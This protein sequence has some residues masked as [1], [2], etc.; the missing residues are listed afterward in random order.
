MKVPPVEIIDTLLVESS[1]ISV[2]SSISSSPTVDYP[3][4]Q[5]CSSCKKKKRL[6]VSPDIGWVWT[7]QRR[8]GLRFGLPC[9][10]ESTGQTETYPY[11][12]PI[13]DIGN[14]VFWKQILLWEWEENTFPE[15]S[16][17]FVYY[18]TIKREINRRLPYECRCDERLKPKTKRSTP[19]TYTGWSG[20]LEPFKI[21][22]RLI[23][24]RFS[25]VMGECVIVTVKVLSLYSK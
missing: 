7:N 19:L 25:S 8:I 2:W 9:R 22:T 21:E 5:E 10:N 15:T 6:R 13:T 17:K 23:G 14:H 3:P 11:C 20:G 4:R 12:F 18:A 1:S 24:E 16:E